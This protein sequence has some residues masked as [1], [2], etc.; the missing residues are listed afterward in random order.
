M[1]K[2]LRFLLI[3]LLLWNF[4]FNNDLLAQTSQEFWL[5]P[6]VITANHAGKTPIY[7]RITSGNAA[8]TVTISQPANAGFVPIV[9][10]VPANSTLTQDL[11]A[12]VTQLE[13]PSNDMV[14][15]T[16]LHIVSTSDITC[17]YELSPTNNPDIWALKGANGLGTEFYVPVQ[18]IWPNGSYLPELPYTS[19]DIVATEDNTV[20]S[21]YPKTDL[22]F[23]HPALQAYTIFLDEGQTYS[24]SVGK[25]DLAILPS[26]NP[27]GTVIVSNKNIAVSIKDDSV[28]PTG[29]GG[30]RDVMGDQI[31]PT[32]IL[33]M[34]YIAQKGFLNGDDQVY[35]LAID[36]NT[37]VYVDGVYQTT[38]FGGE[39]FRYSMSEDVIYI[40]AT[41]K[42]YVIQN[43]GF[44]C[45]TGMAILSWGC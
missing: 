21:I 9:V 13:T 18:N 22:D 5:A 40:N 7:L 8:A 41:K 42:I 11:S 12:F 26:E 36:N 27:A 6:P 17:Y 4:S 38:L 14:N 39:M 23:S 44:G 43:T 25:F 1:N 19:F 20:V 28:N 3:F 29:Y 34:E 45:E 30:C 31:V 32:N 15:N 24:G 16:G 35:I 10:A 37:Q 2:K 33:G